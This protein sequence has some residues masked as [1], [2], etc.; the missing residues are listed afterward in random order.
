LSQKSVV[1]HFLH[2]GKTKL[3]GFSML[4]GVPL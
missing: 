4:L 1:Q 2:A 3:W